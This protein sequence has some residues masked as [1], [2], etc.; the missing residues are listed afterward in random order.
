MAW[1]LIEQIEHHE[2][3]ITIPQA[4]KLTGFSRK[5]VYDMIKRGEIPLAILGAETEAKRIDPKTWA[6]V[7]QKRNPMMREAHRRS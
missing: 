2:G 5:K 7:L 6:F 3:L 4:A 1:S